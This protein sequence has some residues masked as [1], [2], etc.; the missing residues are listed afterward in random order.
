MVVKNRIRVEIFFTVV[1]PMLAC[2]AMAFVKNMWL[3]Q[4]VMKVD[5]MSMGKKDALS[6]KYSLNGMACGALAVDVC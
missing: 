2:T 1:N 6:A 3:K 5:G 4:T